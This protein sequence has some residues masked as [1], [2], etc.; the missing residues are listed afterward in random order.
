MFYLWYSLVKK[1][2]FKKLSAQTTHHMTHGGYK[3]RVNMKPYQPAKPRLAIFKNQL[4]SSIK[5]DLRCYD[6]T[7]PA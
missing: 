5:F 3:F 1:Y 7:K 6:L 4:S 2:Y